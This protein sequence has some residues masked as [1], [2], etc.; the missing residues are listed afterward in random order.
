MPNQ[1]FELMLNYFNLFQHDLLNV[2][3]LKNDVYRDVI[4]N[5]GSVEFYKHESRLIHDCIAG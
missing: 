5:N 3:R 2:E 4:Q 1:N